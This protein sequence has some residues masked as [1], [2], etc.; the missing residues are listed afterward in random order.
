MFKPHFGTCTEC[1]CS[2]IIVVKSGLCKVCNHRKKGKSFKSAIKTQR[3]TTGELAL[4]RAIWAT[5]PHR[6]EVS[7]DPLGDEFNICFFMHILCKKN[8]PRFRLYDKNIILGTKD[9]HTT[10]DHGIPI[11]PNWDKIKEL[12]E[13]LKLKDREL[14]KENCYEK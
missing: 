4:F 3:K 10:Y 2:R 12:A 11:G 7:G 6:S 9:E 1:N 14:Q 8:Y 13:Q 5:R